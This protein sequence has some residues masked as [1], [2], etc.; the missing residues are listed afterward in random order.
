MKAE[1]FE[2]IRRAKRDEELSVREL[3]RRFGVHRL[4][5]RQALASPWPPPRKVP[6]R[7]SNRKSMARPSTLAAQL[8]Q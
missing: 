5:V 7:R 4:P 8:G 1:L 2:N 3:A 6:E